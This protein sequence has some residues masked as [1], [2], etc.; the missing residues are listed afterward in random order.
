MKKC[1]TIIIWILTIAILIVAIGIFKQYP[2]EGVIPTEKKVT[3]NTVSVTRN[4]LEN[5]VVGTAMQYLYKRK[6]SDYEQRQMDTRVFLTSDGKISY[7]KGSNTQLNKHDITYSFRNFNTT[8]ENISRTNQFFIDC[9]SF[10]MSVYL[11]ALNFDFSS[12]L[13]SEFDGQDIS[14]T[15]NYDNSEK[16]TIKTKKQYKTS[17]QKGNTRVL[18]TSILDNARQGVNRDAPLNNVTYSTAK[19]KNLLKNK[20]VVYY[21]ELIDSRKFDKNN[22]VTSGSNAI[23]YQ[24]EKQV[25]EEMKKILRPGDLI[26]RRKGKEDGDESGHV[27]LFVGNKVRVLNQSNNNWVAETH[28]Y[29]IIESKGGDLK[30]DYSFSNN[31]N[32]NNIGKDAASIRYTEDFDYLIFDSKDIKSMKYLILRPLNEF[33]PKNTSGASD[34]CSIS[35]SHT[36]FGDTVYAYNK[37]TVRVKF[38]DLSTEQY[39]MSEQGKTIGNYNMVRSGSEVR[40]RLRT[41]KENNY[42][43]GFCTTKEEKSIYN[44]GSQKEVVDAIDAA[45]NGTNADKAN[46]L[47]NDTTVN[48]AKTKS[49]VGSKA[50]AGYTGYTWKRLQSTITPSATGNITVT[51][52]IPSWGEFVKCSDNCT[53]TKTDGVVS[54]IT[55]NNLSFSQIKNIE[56]TLKTKGGKATRSIPGFKITKSNGTLTLPSMTIML[57]NSLRSKNNR[58]SIVNAIKNTTSWSNQFDGINKVYQKLKYWTGS[59]SKTLSSYKVFDSSVGNTILTK[60]F[61]KVSKSSYDYQLKTANPLVVP[62][63]YGGKLFRGNDAR[64]ATSGN[65][66]NV[67]RIKYMTE[68]DFELGDVLLGFKL[69]TSACTKTNASFIGYAYIYYGHGKFVRFADN[70]YTYYNQALNSNS[71]LQ[72][73]KYVYSADDLTT[74]QNYKRTAGWASNDYFLRSIYNYDLFVV[75]RPI[76]DSTW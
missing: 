26:V 12:L 20:Y 66:K 72:V 39:I 40:V 45:E 53:Q 50:C 15:K 7:S 22:N 60:Y 71:K 5:A 74:I 35:R 29:G 33:C 48:T 73:T 57:N 34:S 52:K 4:N 56:Y 8:P 69:N 67:N 9:S 41:V 70:K 31:G 13:S 58:E 54:E 55:W 2:S 25:Y 42:G 17:Y 19:N 46:D 59:S 44:A 76:L 49:G 27:V 1:L 11:N 3:T 28:N 51:I 38:N 10:S 23:T 24:N 32:W 21:H 37:A 61:S 65:Q 64:Y 75:L 18:A 62:G 36:Y 16:V 43:F 47:G 63:M 68:A 14:F 6:Y 30:R